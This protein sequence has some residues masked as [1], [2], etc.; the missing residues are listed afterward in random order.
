[1]SEYLTDWSLDVAG[2]TSLK[3]DGKR[4]LNEQFKD[5]REYFSEWRHAKVLFAVSMSW[6]LLWVMVILRPLRTRADLSK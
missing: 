3:N 1:M 6:F 2:E 4:G 5:F